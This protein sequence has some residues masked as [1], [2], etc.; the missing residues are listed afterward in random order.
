MPFKMD[1]PHCH[2][3]LNVTEKAFGKKVPCPNCKQP[4]TVPQWAESPADVAIA[5]DDKTPMP[6]SPAGNRPSPPPIALARRRYIT[7]PWIVLVIAGGI[8]AICAVVVVAALWLNMGN[9]KMC[10][11]LGPQKSAQTFFKTER[12]SGNLGY[13]L[14]VC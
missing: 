7:T 4:V 3:T 14:S 2:R 12:L 9:V 13:F 8:A 5:A 1:C 10:S 11:N 6:H